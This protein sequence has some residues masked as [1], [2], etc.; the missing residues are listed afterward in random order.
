MMIMVIV[1]GC[2]YD[3]YYCDK[4]TIGW[5]NLY[6]IIVTGHDS[7]SFKYMKNNNSN[8]HIRQRQTA[9]DLSKDHKYK[10]IKN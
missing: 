3:Y 1:Y 10:R 6:Y 9:I 4:R 2:G 8:H 7:S 5:D